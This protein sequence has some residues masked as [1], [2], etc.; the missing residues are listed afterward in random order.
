[1][2]VE[3][4]KLS[5]NTLLS[6]SLPY[7]P[8]IDGLRAFAVLS[9]V[10][11]H[12][13][14][15]FLQGGFIGVDVFFVIS[16]YLITWILLQDMDR[17]T[18]SFWGFYRRRVRRIFPSLV[19]ILAATLCL[20]WFTL[21]Q[22]E[23]REVG[24]H[25]LGGATF[26]ANILLWNET[27]GYFDVAA[28]AKPLLHLWSLGI[29]EQ[30]YIFFPLIL[31]FCHKKN[32]S[33]I[34]AIFVLF[35]LSF[36]C[37]IYLSFVNRTA[38]FYS[39]FSRFWELFT[40]CMLSIVMRLASTRREY[41]RPDIFLRKTL[42][43][44]LSRGDGHSL[45]L[46]FA[47][48]GVIVLGI[49]LSVTDH[50]KT[51]PGWPALLPVLGTVLFIVAGPLNPISKYALCNRFTV[52]IGKISYPF[53]LWHWVLLS[54]AFI[55][56][57]GG[58]ETTV[59]LKLLLV[60]IAFFLSILT[61]YIIERPIRF[62]KN[63]KRLRIACVIM[64]MVVMAVLGGTVYTHNGLPNRD[65]IKP[66]D[67]IAA[68]V[69]NPVQVESGGFAY[70]GIGKNALRYCRYT[71]V[72]APT[73]VAVIGDSHANAAYYGIAEMGKRLHYNTVL[74][75]WIV[76]AAN[77]WDNYMASDIEIIFNILK[78]KNDIKKVFFVARGTFY[79]IGMQ[80]YTGN[81][82][83]EQI[84]RGLAH[85]VGGEN[86]RQS[87]QEYVDRLNSLGKNVYIVAENPELPINLRDYIPR[88]LRPD[89]LIKLPEIRLDYV[90]GR[91]SAY[92]RLLQE[93]HEATI[94]ETI[95][96]FCPGGTCRMFT[97]DGMPLYNDDDHL[98]LVGSV[99]QAKE[100]FM[101]Y[102]R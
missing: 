99:F 62:E 61:Y 10:C 1:M 79:I 66:Y 59:L 72:G 91:Q 41:R 64:A 87:L 2:A 53:Y 48:L 96:K 88:P 58:G 4:H 60:A 54:Y 101:P 9:V 102:L 18:F 55:I 21:F 7:R 50:G 20:G 47:V 29:E 37:N 28:N 12:A 35:L 82:T 23:F 68:V 39:P 70:A 86:Y 73:T 3:S 44:R 85:R 17:G 30:F 22:D 36:V 43:I 19:V 49:A 16:G 89:M 8:D 57:G 98:S 77:I 74:L 95:P 84:K 67:N 27:G 46:A 51:F 42:R 100:I 75:G 83:D 38:D 45:S 52:F 69:Q 90:M 26:I 81:R 13:F 25:V 14:P 80:T 71:D 94:I 31:Y 76:P 93:I 34:T 65:A 24:K 5:R 6:G 92:L 11:Y 33:F 15:E 40:G 97:D 56:L 78:N 32:V 63:G